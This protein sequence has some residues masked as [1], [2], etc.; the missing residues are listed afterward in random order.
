M[1]SLLINLFVHKLEMADVNMINYNLDVLNL[2]LMT[3]V[4]HHKLILMDAIK[5]RNVNGKI[6]N[7]NV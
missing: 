5:L 2:N 7:A 6:I 3:Y 1:H 4:L